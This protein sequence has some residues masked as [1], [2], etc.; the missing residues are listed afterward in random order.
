VNE[1]IYEYKHNYRL[2]LVDWTNYLKDVDRVFA[3]LTSHSEQNK[4]SQTQSAQSDGFLAASTELSAPVEMASAES[5]EDPSHM[6]GESLHLALPT[7]LRTLHLD[8]PTLSP[9]SKLEWNNDIPEVNHLNSEHWRND[10]TEIW[11][12]HKE[13]NH[14]DSAFSGNGMT[15]LGLQP[16]P[17]LQPISGHQRELPQDGGPEEDVFEG[18]LYLPV[19]SDGSSVHQ[20]FNV[21]N[22]EQPDLSSSVERTLTKVKNYTHENAQQVEG[23]AS[24]LPPSG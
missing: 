9:E 5:D 1:S 18:Q 7:D 10:K 23:S 11:M 8:R 20:V 16:H 19:H 3:L 4:I 17:R 21:S 6:V 13:I 15:E 14:P 24:S 12:G 22:V 2:S